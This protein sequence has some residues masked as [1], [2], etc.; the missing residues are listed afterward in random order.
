MLL[1]I[2]GMLNQHADF[3]INLVLGLTFVGIAT[4]VVGVMLVVASRLRLAML[5]GQ[6]A[7]SGR[8]Q[9]LCGLVGV[10]LACA[11]VAAGLGAVPGAT[12]LVGGAGLGLFACVA[13]SLSCLAIAASAD[14]N[15]KSQPQIVIKTGK[16]AGSAPGSGT[17]SGTAEGANTK[18]TATR[19]A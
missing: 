5:T 15:K 13:A 17:G 10:V 8:V 2:Q 4:L 7:L 12:L 11:S 3:I 1:R 14:L 6:I 18:K 16:G 9:A 19:A